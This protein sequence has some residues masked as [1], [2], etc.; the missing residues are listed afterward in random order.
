MTTRLSPAFAGHLA[1]ASLL[2]AAGG[3]SGQCGNGWTPIPPGLAPPARFRHAMA[4]DPFRQRTVL[5]GGSNSVN[6]FDPFLG[7]TWEFDGTT[8]MPRASS[9][10]VARWR[11]AMAWDGT[12]VL[13]FGGS[14]PVPGPVL[15]DLWRWDGTSW[16]Q[17]AAAGPSARALA[18]MA[19]DSARGRVVL[20]GGVAGAARGD[21]WEWNGS[22]GQW[23]QRTPAASPPPR[24]GHAMAFDAQRGL[25]VLFGGAETRPSTTPGSSTPPPRAAREPGSSERPRSPRRRRNSS[26]TWPTTPSRG[27]S[28]FSGARAPRPRTTPGSGTARHGNA[29]A[30]AARPDEP[31]TPWPTTTASERP[32]SSA[33]TARASSLTPGLGTAPADPRRSL[34]STR[35]TSP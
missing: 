27:A 21:T 12:G 8:W 11:H 34:R 31:G 28:S 1:A 15:G 25:V 20:F 26:P 14:L 32:S 5:F 24:Y 35:R 2:A 4:Y 18:T 9:G 7:D 29:D 6:A 23:T 13:V 10:P 33:A 22:I 17:L 3:A 19:Y 16:T 30:P